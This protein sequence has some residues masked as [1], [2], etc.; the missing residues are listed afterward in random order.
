MV[1][2]GGLLTLPLLAALS[3]MVLGVLGG[4]SAGC[5]AV[6]GDWLCRVASPPPS[7]SFNACNGTDDRIFA[8]WRPAQSSSSAATI[9]LRASRGRSREWA[10]SV[11]AATAS[12]A[13]RF[14]LDVIGGAAWFV[15]RATG[16]SVELRQLEPRRDRVSAAYELMTED[17]DALTVTCPAGVVW[18]WTLEVDRC[19]EP[20]AA[21][22]SRD[23]RCTRNI[24][25]PPCCMPGYEV[26]PERP[27]SSECLK[28]E[29]GLLTRLKTPPC[30]TPHSSGVPLESRD[31]YAVR[32]RHHEQLGVGAGMLV[33]LGVGTFAVAAL[34][35]A[36]AGAR[37]LVLI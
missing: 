32:L 15:S 18:Q 12:A 24:G 10:H 29:G 20:T 30:Q 16:A 25:E 9:T 19:G 1:V 36:R 31:F 34:Q 5:Q 6:T 3:A 13:S 35:R 26:E 27:F 4:A 2:D 14:T 21:V 22:G 17:S 33:G 11:E 28:T 7:S 23:V 37:Q 8:S